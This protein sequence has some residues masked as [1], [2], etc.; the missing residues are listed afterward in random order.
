MC[1]DKVSSHMTRV[2]GFKSEVKALI[3]DG[4]DHPA[5]KKSR[6]QIA[7]EL[8]VSMSI[9]NNYAAATMAHRFPLDLLPKWFFVTRSV[10]LLKAVVEACG[11]RLATVDDM[12][13]AQY[14]RDVIDERMNRGALTAVRKMEL[15]KLKQGGERKL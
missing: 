10:E 1:D 5:H 6:E 3:K 13:F 4:I 14:G 11:Y 9:L 2:L 8:G 15:F 12:K 7:E